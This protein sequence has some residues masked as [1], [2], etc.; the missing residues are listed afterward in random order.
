MP[1][2]VMEVG[3]MR[4]RM[5]QRLVPMP[6][7]VRF[8]GRVCGAVRVLVMFVMIMEMFVLHR[9]MPVRMLMA[10]RQ[11]QPNTH[12]HQ[13]ACNPQNRRHLFAQQKNGNDCADKWRG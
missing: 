12:C 11:M 10:L 5:D 9:F 8:S 6:M 13:C 4:V 1:V 3:I 2:P 7:A